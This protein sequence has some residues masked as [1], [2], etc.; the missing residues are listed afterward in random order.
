MKRQLFALLILGFILA[1][2]LSGEREVNAQT[3]GNPVS[4]FL[5]NQPSGM[6]GKEWKVTTITL[7]PG[8]VDAR[9]V[10]PGTGLVYVL[11]GGGILQLDGT[12]SLALHPGVAATL[13]PEKAHV[14]KNTSETQTLR[15]LIVVHADTAT[16][17]EKVAK[18]PSARQ[19]GLGF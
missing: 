14:L 5:Q 1:G 9:S 6:N 13:N 4:T 8:A 12:A 11:E 15:I 19:G 3:N 2:V 18:K 7:S 16:Q 10:R 17:G